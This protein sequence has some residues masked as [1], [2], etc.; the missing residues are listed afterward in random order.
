M[1]DFGEAERRILGFMSEGTEFVFEGKEYAVVLSG[2]PTCRKGEPKTDIY[3]LAES[4]EGDIE[5]KISYKKENADFIGNKMSAERAEQLFGEDWIDIIEHSTTA[6]QDKFY[7]RML[8][9][10]NG[11][12][13][14][15]KGSIT[16]GWKFELL[17]KSGGDLSGKMLLTDEQVVDVYAGS[18]LSPDKKNASVCGQIIRD[19]GVANYIL[20]DENVHSAQDVIDKMIPIR[21]YVM[22]HPDI[23][24]ACKALN[25]RTFAEK[26]DGNRPLSVQVNWD[27]INNRL[28]PELVFDKPLIVKGDEVAERLIHYMRKLNIRTTEDIDEDN[29]GTD[30]IV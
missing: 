10:K 6:I 29:S 3:I 14:T 1:G 13:R 8:I 28:V 12:R 7:E 22:M 5:I 16:L 17:N 18:N 24:F 23:Y 30:K 11:F 27:A 9:Y 19:S 20:M 4:D 2:K 21:E 26:W 25:Y 15:E